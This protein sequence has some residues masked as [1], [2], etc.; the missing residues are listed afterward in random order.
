LGKNEIALII[1]DPCDSGTQ[2]RAKQKTKHG[3]IWYTPQSGIWQTVWLESLPKTFVKSMTIVPDIDNGAVSV[4]LDI[5]GKP[6]IATVEILDGGKQISKAQ[7]KG[8]EAVLKLK[9]FECWS[10]ENPKLYDLVITVDDDIVKSYCGM[11][12]FSVITDEKGV[13]RL[14]LNNKPYFHNGVLDQGYWSDG[15]LTPPTDSAML[16][17]IKLM[18]DM[19]FNMLRKHIK[20]E[21]LRWYYHCDKLGMIVWQDMVSGGG[22]YN[23]LAI[24]I[25]PFVNIKIKDTKK[26]YKL[27]A[28]DDESGRNEYYKDLKTMIEYL[29]NVVSLGVWVPFNEGWGQFE[30]VKATNFVKELDSTRVIDSVSGWNDQGKDSSDLKSLHV[31]F[32]PIRIPREKR[33][34]VL[35]EF[36][37]YSIA[38]EGH[39]FNPSK[40]FGYRIY[41]NPEN[42]AAAYKTL[43]EKH[44]VPQI[45]KGLS[46]TVYTQLSDVEEEINGFIT[47]DRK[48]V[49]LPIELVK[50]V[51]SQI[52]L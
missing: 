40:L 41:K 9:E 18:K 33:C 46:A 8:G 31:Y 51:N 22:K 6:Q 17:D 48:V 30:S 4:K 19:G 42:F 10:P 43:F 14:A 44:I 37:G 20:I 27:L 32:K 24:G 38:T 25:L 11:R 15:M 50:D 52:K 47:Y 39:V 2:A 45:A 29:K 13:K 28:R 49:K 16:Y 21:P 34:V 3:G 26:N 36:G 7:V 1:T 35:S 5:E 12:K 23:M